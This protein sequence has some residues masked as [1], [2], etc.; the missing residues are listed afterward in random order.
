MGVLEERAPDSFYWMIIALNQFL[1]LTY[2]ESLSS[3]YLY[4]EIY[5]ALLGHCLPH[6]FMASPS[7]SPLYNS[8]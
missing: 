5:Y 6:F 4:N 7:A 1:L 8:I 3:Q 2:L